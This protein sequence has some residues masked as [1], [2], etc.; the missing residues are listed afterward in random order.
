MFF[1]TTDVPV[2]TVSSPTYTQN[3]AIRTVTCNPS[4]NPDSYIYHKWQHKSKY[5]DLIREFGGNKTL[6]LPDITV[7]LRYQDSG[8]Y[9]CT[10]SNGFED[11]NN[12]FE[13][14]GYG[15]VTVKAQPVF[16]SD[17]I[18]R[19]KQFGEID[20]TVVIYVDVYSV[21]KFTSS[22]WTRDGK[23]ITTQ[24]STKYQSSSSPTIVKDTIYGKEIQQDGYNLTLTIHDLK[25]EDFA[26][27]TVTLKNG[28]SDVN[29]TIV[30]ESASVPETPG[31]FSR[32]DS[33]STSFTV[34]W[35][36]NSGG[37]YKQTFYIQYRVQGSSEW[38]TV[39][40][41]EEDINEQRRRRTYEVRNLEGGTAYEL[42]MFAEN[43][44]MKRSNFTDVLIVFT[45][46]SVSTTSSAVIGAVVAVVVTLVIVCA[47]FIVIL[48]IKRTQGKDKKEKNDTYYENTGFQDIQN[49]DEYEEVENK[50]DVEHTSSSKTYET[51]ST[52]DKIS[53]Y[54]DLENAKDVTSSK[55][56][57][58]D[59][60]ALGVQ[61]KP[62][63]YSEMK[64]LKEHRQLRKQQADKKQF[65]KPND[66]G[67]N[68][69][70]N[71]SQV[72]TEKVY[73]NEV[74]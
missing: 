30:L 74:F 46:S 73:E 52:K 6:T 54:D 17:T 32:I 12:Q 59:Y 31:N 55:S 15:L 72:P 58:G 40:A 44:A 1:I 69:E 28:F 20:K 64:N 22:I 9:W 34:Q 48:L 43:T 33:A 63:I 53:V 7:L 26:K 61:D 25:A 37:G 10:A 23:P 45:E 57:I 49:G 42:R 8:E 35:D 5:G 2:I 38:T 41:G 21:P 66:P 29:F 13:Q 51:L 11:K 65:K 50:I 4:G 14:T 27:Y 36:P 62:S 47:S 68:T 39:S 18:D 19:V 71:T 3:D 67:E 70:L 16:T 60:E 24:N 56:S